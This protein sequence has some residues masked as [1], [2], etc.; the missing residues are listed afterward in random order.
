MARVRVAMEFDQGE[1][2][3]HPVAELTSKHL[4]PLLRLLALGDVVYGQQD[5]IEVVQATSV[6][7]HD[8]ATDA[9]EVVFHLEIIKALF[10]RKNFLQESAEL[11]DVPLAIA[12]VVNEPPLGVC[13]GNLK[14]LVKGLIGMLHTKVPVQY[15]QRLAQRVDYLFGIF[16]LPLQLITRLLKFRDVADREEDQVGSIGSAFDH[17]RIEQV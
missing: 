15:E 2:V 1:K 13:G 16:F 6:Q 11:G 14:G 10:L 3:L 17:V 9:V 12:D 8:P 5:Q 7:Q 4:L